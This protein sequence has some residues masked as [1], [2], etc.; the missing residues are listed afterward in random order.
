MSRRSV[1]FQRSVHAGVRS[2]ESGVKSQNIR[3]FI[4][5]QADQLS[6][7][8]NAKTRKRENEIE[9]KGKSCGF[10][11]GNVMQHVAMDLTMNQAERLVEKIRKMDRTLKPKIVRHEGQYAVKMDGIHAEFAQMVLHFRLNCFGKCPHRKRSG[12]KLTRPED[13]L[14]QLKARHP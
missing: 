9:I 1:L 5:D 4:S 8:E 7:R 3:G 14:R 6:D 13:L 10:H 11:S 2:Q 12:P